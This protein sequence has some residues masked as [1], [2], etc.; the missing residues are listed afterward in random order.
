MKT[1]AKLRHDLKTITKDAV[2]LI[3]AQRISTIKD[4]HQIVVLNQGK[5]VGKGTHLEL[6]R[7]CK[8]YRE[9]A[10][11]QLSEREFQAEIKKSTQLTKSEEKK[12][13]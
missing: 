9:I 7:K 8:V 6:L 13:A 12:H 1:D 2:T 10:Q 5:V 11:S 4:A 3:V